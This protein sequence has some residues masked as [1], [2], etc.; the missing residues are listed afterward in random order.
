[1]IDFKK[2]VVKNRPKSHKDSGR[3]IGI[4]HHDIYLRLTTKSR[5]RS[6]NLKSKK[7]TLQ[8]GIKSEAERQTVKKTTGDQQLL[9]MGKTCKALRA[10]K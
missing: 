8:F 1:M 3:F 4:N 2:S 6:R 7:C 5:S 10:G 9:K